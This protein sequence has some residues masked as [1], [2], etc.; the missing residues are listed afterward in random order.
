VYYYYL[1]AFCSYISGTLTTKAVMQGVGVGD[2][3]AT[4]LAATITWIMRDGTG[5]I[6]R[7]VFASW[8]G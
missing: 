6:G 5:M 7:I 1:Q 8:K 4:P 3:A 2:A